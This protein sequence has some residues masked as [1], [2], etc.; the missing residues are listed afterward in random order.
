MIVAPPPT[1]RGDGFVLRPM[2]LSDAP[3]LRAAGQGD[4]IG[5]YT[6]LPWPFSLAAAEELIADAEVGWQAG[7]AAR[8]AIIVERADEPALAGTA[9]LL[10]LFPERADA[11]VGYWLAESARGRGLARRAV[12]LLC[13]WALGPFGLRRLHLLV[14]LDNAGSHAVARSCGFLPIGEV[15]WQHPTDRSKDAICLAYER[16]GAVGSR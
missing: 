16:L 9:S 2:A 1:L 3:A 6:S 10:H 14:D 15:P 11:E 13:D 12:A 7:T 4:A 8:F 5:R